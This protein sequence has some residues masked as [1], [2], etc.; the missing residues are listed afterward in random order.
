[1]GTKLFGEKLLNNKRITETQL[2]MALEH[3]RL[4]GGRIGQSMVALEFISKDELTSFFNSVPLPPD[5]LAGTGLTLTFI[6]ELILKHSLAL[7]EFSIPEMAD[8]VKLC[9][10]LV[11]EAIETLRQ[12]RLIQVRETGRL[13]RMTYRFILTETGKQAAVDLF[14]ISRY[15]G[16]A[17][18]PI[19]EY[20]NMVEMQ[21]IKNILVDNEAVRKAFS[22]MVLEDN[23]LAQLGP[24]VSS[25][26]AIFLHGPPGNGKTS[27]AEA[28]GKVLPGEIHVPYS[29]MA[30]G[31]IITVYDRASHQAIEPDNVHGPVDRRW[32]L[33]KRPVVMVGGEM[34][35]KGLDLAFN[36]ISKFYEAPLQ[37]KANNG[38]FIVDDFGRQQI[39][40]QNL[41]NRWIVP[42]ERRTDFLTFQSGMKIEIPFD[43]LVIFST[44][45]EPR[46]LV[47]EAFLRR[48]R[49]KI[50]IDHPEL[51]NYRKIFKRV[52]MH[53]AITFSEEAFDFLV[54]LYSA[55]NNAPFSSCHCRDI[56]DNIIDRAHYNGTKPELTKKTLADSWKSYFVKL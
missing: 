2:Q 42:L 28:I 23:L 19:D 11:D 21:T 50:K 26:K 1:M 9:N 36:P 18:V 8:R 43:Q 6:M 10:S 30:E 15:A 17:P 20:R 34:T 54:E 7:R 25:G 39:D 46:D 51:G 14:E 3:Q 41:L 13:S 22:N 52:C 35:L 4:H 29:V 32:V 53:N 47:D 45:L 40:P 16:P 55:E 27:I 44:N 49:Y 37:M 24:A 38:L 12:D 48:I 31:E 56:I 5:T 33:V